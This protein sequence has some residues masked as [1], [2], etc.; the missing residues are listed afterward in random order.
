[1]TLY[2]WV[3]T[4]ESAGDIWYFIKHDGENFLGWKY[5]H[6]DLKF[7]GNNINI[8]NS[9]KWTYSKIPKQE[10]NKFVEKKGWRNFIKKN[11]K[12]I[13]RKMVEDILG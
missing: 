11:E 1:M 2:K 10:G 3:Y 9:K 4:T 12:L 5:D 7:Y 6:K 8:G 13:K